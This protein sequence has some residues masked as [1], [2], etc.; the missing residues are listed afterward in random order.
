M[1]TTPLF[2][3][4]ATHDDHTAHLALD[5]EMD[6]EAVAVFHSQVCLCLSS[7]PEALVLDLGRLSFCDCA[8]LNLLLWARE[9][10]LESGASFTLR[11][12]RTQPGR[13]FAVSGTAHLLGTGQSTVTLA[14]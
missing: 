9:R 6:M 12:V 11:H 1:T 10:A 14:S 5:G 8:G 3:V 7:R 2:G 4:R 13:L